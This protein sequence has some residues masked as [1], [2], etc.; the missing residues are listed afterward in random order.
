MPKKPETLFAEKFDRILKDI[1]GHEIVIFNIQ[2]KTRRG[3]PDRLIC[4]RGT[5]LAVELKVQG[6]RLA[7]LQ[8]LKLKEVRL[9]RGLALVITPE[10][11]DS[12][13][14]DLMEVFV[15]L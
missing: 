7:P 14:D 10:T 13:L 4:I 11:L 2:Q 15:P 5:F 12:A 8:N 6:G 3:D 1:Y 9:A